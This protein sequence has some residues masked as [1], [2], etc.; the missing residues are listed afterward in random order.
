MTE[1]AAGEPEKI[2]PGTNKGIYRNPFIVG[3][4]TVVY[5]L[6]FAICATTDF[7]W[8]VMFFMLTL[9]LLF[10]YV[11]EFRIFPTLYMHEVMHKVAV[12]SLFGI[13]LG[14]VGFLASTIVMGDTQGADTTP[15][16]PAGKFGITWLAV[17]LPAYP[18]T[19]WM[20]FRVNKRDLEEEHRIREEKRKQKKKGGPPIMTKDGF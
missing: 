13:L 17:S 19:V 18:L 8:A 20:L 6:V 9:G 3:L 2:P 1:P 16:S 10:A 15:I 11:T 5:L 12:A 14:L 4:W 7:L